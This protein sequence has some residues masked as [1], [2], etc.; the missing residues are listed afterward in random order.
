MLLGTSVAAQQASYTLF[1]Q[2]SLTLQN[3]GTLAPNPGGLPIIGNGAFSMTLDVQPALGISFSALFASAS[4]A[5][6]PILGI[7][8][9]VGPPIVVLSLPAPINGT[10]TIPIAIPNNTALAQIPTYW[11]SVHI[12]S[13][14]HA[15][16]MGDVD[17]D[18]DL[19]RLSLTKTGK[20]LYKLKRRYRDGSTHV[21]LDPMTLI[22]RLAALVPRPRAHLTTYHSGDP[23][24]A[25]A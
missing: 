5:S 25:C 8:V 19:D 16:A 14:T 15:V 10:V 24:R 20:V 21:V 11:Q 3:T 12:D 22:E 1:G 9:L 7:E 13:V 2:G 6:T 4:R 23:S 18:R 17:G